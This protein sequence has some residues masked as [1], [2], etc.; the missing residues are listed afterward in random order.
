LNLLGANKHAE[1]LLAAPPR[2]AV[3]PRRR[4][5]HTGVVGFT[6][7]KPMDARPG[8]PPSRQAHLGLS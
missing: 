1:E 4:G 6:G 2:R 5:G 7:E 3:R 8:G